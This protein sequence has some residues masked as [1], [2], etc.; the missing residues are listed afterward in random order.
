MCDLVMLDIFRGL[1]NLVKIS[2][3]HIDSP[4][5]RL[6]YSITVMILIAF[7]LIV[8]T[9]QYV[10]NPIDC[11]HTKD[12]P[13]DV[14]N[15]FCWIHSTYTMK[16]AFKKKVGV[17]VPYKGVDSS[18]GNTE[19][20]KCYMY[21][22]ITRFFK[23]HSYTIDSP[24]FKLHYKVTVGI[25]IGFCV[26]LAARQY[27]GDPI[28]CI[29]ANH[30]GKDILNM[31]CW[32]HSTY[33]VHS[34]FLLQIGLDIPYP[35]VEN[36]RRSNDHK[37]HHFYQWV[38]FCLFFQAILFYT[39]RWLWKNWE[40]GKIHA[41]MMDLDV[42]ICSE[43][44]KKQK[45]KLLLDYLWD[46]LK[47]HN[48]WA[49]RYYF[50]ELLALANVIGQMFLMNRF[51]DGAFLTFGIDVISFVES[52]QEDRV[53]PMIYIFP[54]MTKCTFYKYGVSGEVERLDAVCILPLNVVNEKI[55]IFLWFW[56]LILFVL[57]SGCIL[58]RIII[59]LSPR[60]RVY[61]LRLRFRLIRRDAIDV[62]V[63]KSKMGD[64]FLIYML[65]ENVDS[66]I[67]RD[68]MHELAAR[69]GHRHHL[70][71]HPSSGLGGGKEIQEA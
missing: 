30:V 26:M 63:C 3:I 6:H 32:I 43:I 35:G 9:R 67:F 13:E 54:R 41:L 33:S 40:G 20:R 4:I 58:Y 29:D 7:S 57:T 51:F 27:V 11:I 17:E 69:L 59:I 22:H 15:T 71:I 28:E 36:S 70:H 47:F 2:H 66:L 61:L 65:G 60:M 55:Y 34:A 64:W 24:I 52:D 44:E 1:R 49:Y 48:W 12:I 68:V 38:A 56:F 37:V 39:P 42:G 45:K 14:L 25:L 21:Y 18:K 62:I 10:G 50:C 23:L 16:S 46:N 31:F 19:D 53:D 5:F 8:T